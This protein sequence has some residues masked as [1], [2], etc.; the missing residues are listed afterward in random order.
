[1]QNKGFLF[2][3]IIRQFELVEDL[4]VMCFDKLSITYCKIYQRILK[5]FLII[6]EFESALIWGIRGKSFL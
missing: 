5:Q 4:L 6:L 2:I 1:M 3:Y